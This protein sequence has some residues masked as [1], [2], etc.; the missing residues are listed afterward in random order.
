[1]DYQ[2]I[3]YGVDDPVATITFN[4]P[5]RLN[6]L[7][8]RTIMELRH[9]LAEAERSEDVVGIVL[10]GAGRGFCAG[11]DMET[12]A[13]MQRAGTT[14]LGDLVPELAAA[15]PGDV[16]L[17][18]DFEH[19][20]AFFMSLR[21]PVLAAINGPCAG[22]GFSIAMLCDLRLMAETAIFN[23]AFA[24]RGLV[25]EQ[26][27]SWVL[28]RLIGAA[29][30]LDVLWTDRKIDAHEALS[31]GLVSRVMAQEQV[32]AEAQGY[33]RQLAATASPTS[34]MHIKRQVYSDLMRPLGVALQE[35]DRL[36]EASIKWPDLKEGI[37]AFVEKR[38]PKFPRIGSE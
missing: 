17:G 12:L 28:P 22:L 7:T 2:E 21:K 34:L 11:L 32:L 4:R 27:M 13:A 37:A 31:L 25:A 36:M 24:Q 35:T 10:T 9:A 5:D 15:R 6:A 14:N 18:P 38:P 16:E 23:T 29:R 8:T 20:F 30:A 26:G 1:M 3:L 33:L 19:G